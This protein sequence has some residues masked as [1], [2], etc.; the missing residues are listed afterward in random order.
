V[1]LCAQLGFITYVYPCLMLTYFGQGAFLLQHP[2]KAYR[3][4]WEA[5][6]PQMFWLMFVAA[7]LA[8]IV[9]SQ[10]LISG[11]FSIIKQVQNN[12]CSV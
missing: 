7:I 6:P 9:A 4:F 5:M 1:L 10:A 11:C 8:S 3:T 12:A 2:D